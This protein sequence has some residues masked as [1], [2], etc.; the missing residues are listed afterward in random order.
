M[1]AITSSQRPAPRQPHIPTPEVPNMPATRTHSWHFPPH[2]AGGPAPPPRQSR[3]PVT[4]A[5]C[6]AKTLPPEPHAPPVNGPGT[7]A[8][9]RD[10]KKSK[11]SRETQ[12]NSPG[13]DRHPRPNSQRQPR[14]QLE[15]PLLSLAF[16]SRQQT[17]RGSYTWPDSVS[18]CDTFL[19]RGIVRASAL[20]T[21]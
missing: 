4:T 3:I 10:P 12:N 18:T 1:K 19:E 8:K 15:G 9:D 17:T 7:E 2:Q 11:Q 21:T 6:P 14:F 5:H 13:T 20:G 16:K